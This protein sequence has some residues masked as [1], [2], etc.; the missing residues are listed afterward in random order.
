MGG[1]HRGLP[2]TAGASTVDGSA[3]LAPN[4]RGA[5]WRADRDGFIRLPLILTSRTYATA[6]LIVLASSS[7]SFAVV[8]SRLRH[9]LGVESS[10][11]DFVQIAVVDHP[12][13]DCARHARGLFP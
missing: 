9:L 1:Y 7:L 12:F 10:G 11:C 2:V 8:S 13:Q 6:V 5:N 4:F 3:L